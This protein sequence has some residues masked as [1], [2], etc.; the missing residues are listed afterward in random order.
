M[1][2]WRAYKSLEWFLFTG[3]AMA[4]FVALVAIMVLAL[5]IPGQRMFIGLVST[6]TVTP[7]L[8]PSPLDTTGWQIY[9]NLKY[10]VEFQYPNEYI[11]KQVSDGYILIRPPDATEYDWLLSIQIEPPVGFATVNPSFSE[12]ADAVKLF[13]AADG[14]GGSKYCD[15][16]LL[17][18]PFKNRYNIDGYEMYLNEIQEVGGE[19][20]EKRRRGPVFVLNISPNVPQRMFTIE[21]TE[22]EKQTPLNEMILRKI[23]DTVKISQ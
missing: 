8:A 15:D 5:K 9:R 10:N 20:I 17:K 1:R 14:P 16:I 22:T 12:A 19:I 2:P 6:P 18:T 11:L 7:S 23:L 3:F 21:F 4:G 13:C